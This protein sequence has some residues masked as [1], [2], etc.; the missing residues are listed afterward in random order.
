MLISPHPNAG[1]T[2]FADSQYAEIAGGA[3]HHFLQHTYVPDYIAA[4]GGEMED[5]VSD[6][7]ARSVI[8]DVAAAAGLVKRDTFLPQNIFACQQML[9]LAVAA[10]RDHVGMLTEEQHVVNGTGFARGDYAF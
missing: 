9:T 2:G 5:G 8:G 7:L 3:D 1:F 6:N 4:D 10:L